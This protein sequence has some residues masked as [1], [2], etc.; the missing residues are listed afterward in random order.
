MIASRRFLPVLLALLPG[1]AEDYLTMKGGDTAHQEPPNEAVEDY[2]RVDVF[3]SDANPTLQPE[4]H[5]LDETWEGLAIDMAGPASLSGEVVGYDAAPWYAVEVP[6]S[7]VP[8]KARVSL[9]KPGT[10]MAA[11]VTS[12]ADADGAFSLRL[13]SSSGYVF[14]VVPLEPALLP[15]L[16]EQDY[17]LAADHIGERID[18]GYG[19]PVFG[20]VLDDAG[21][22][23]PGLSTTVRV[24]EPETGIESTPVAVDETGAFQL[25]VQ[26]GTSYEIILAG[27]VGD[28]VPTYRQTVMVENEDGAQ[29]DFALGSLEP[30][31]VSGRVLADDGS[32]AVS[33]ATVRFTALELR[34][35]PGGELV[36]DDVT[37]SRGEFRVALLAGR[38]KTEFIAPVSWELSPALETVD[39]AAGSP[40]QDLDQRLEALSPVSC[41]VLGPTG[42]GLAG[43]SV[44]ATEEGFDGY[45]YT[46]ITAEDGRFALDVPATKLHFAL[47]P[48]EGEAAVTYLE[49]PVEDFPP[50]IMLDQGD[51]ISGTVQHDGEPVAWAL[52]EVRNSEEQIYATTLTDEDGGF[53]VRV[54]WEGAE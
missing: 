28:I 36:V 19:A 23:F 12:D 40:V 49:V 30:V 21:Q 32:V 2:L 11:S 46:T 17:L 47:T 15:M 38:Y 54:H 51:V 42:R 25:R 41:Q 43:V 13:P 5:I 16:V 8:V 52:I 18:L 45:T 22:T 24:R 1:C 35:H 50:I 53:E 20:R 26:S 31:E 48:P 33:N 7:T 3:P 10:I 37:S 4:T 34:D 27:S 6:G 29:I 44:V 9:S 14:S 39:I